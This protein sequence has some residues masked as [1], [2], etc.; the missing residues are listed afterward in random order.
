MIK[1]L[2]DIVSL[3]NDNIYLYETTYFLSILGIILVMT[4]NYENMLYCS[5][6]N[7]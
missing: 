6:I 7:I 2:I 4:H 1:S 5:M 3:K